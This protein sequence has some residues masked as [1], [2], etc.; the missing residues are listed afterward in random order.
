MT[1]NTVGKRRMRPLL[2]TAYVHAMICAG[3][4]LGLAAC[5]P[6]PGHPP[7]GTDDPAPS[8]PPLPRGCADGVQAQLADGMRI[9]YIGSLP[10][11]RDVCLVRWDGHEHRYFLGFWGSGLFQNAPAAE[12]DALRRVLSGPVGAE[13]TFPLRHGRL[14]S[15][16]TVTH[17]ADALIDVD[18]QKR[19]TAELRV[20][21]HERSDVPGAD[22]ETLYWIDRQT[23]ITL[24]QQ[25]VTPMANGEQ[26][27]STV[28]EVRRL[29]APPAAASKA[30]SG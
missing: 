4:V 6:V 22:S 14:W 28:W 16:A 7:G 29:M 24:R 12:R 1:S 8:S 3:A 20:L 27:R 5:Q 11:D 18:G 25:V 21:H 10:G 15:D 23:G 17:V 26:L 30:P 13:A 2:A 9:D 19:A